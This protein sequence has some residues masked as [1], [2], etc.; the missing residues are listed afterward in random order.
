MSLSDRQKLKAL[1]MGVTISALT[2]ASTATADSNAMKTPDAKEIR[3]ETVAA[4]ARGNNDAATLQLS[5]EDFLAARVAQK[6]E[7]IRENGVEPEKSAADMRH[8]NADDKQDDNREKQQADDDRERF[9]REQADKDFRRERMEKMFSEKTTDSVAKELLKAQTENTDNQPDLDQLFDQLFETETK[10][11]AKRVARELQNDPQFK[12]SDLSFSSREGQR[13]WN[14]FVVDC[15]NSRYLK[16]L[17]KADKD[18]AAAKFVNDFEKLHKNIYSDQCYEEAQIELYKYEK[19]NDEIVEKEEKVA[20]EKINN[21]DPR[22]KTIDLN[23]YYYDSDTKIVDELSKLD[24]PAVPKQYSYDEDQKNSATREFISRLRGTSKEKPETAVKK[25][26]H[27]N[28]DQ[29][30]LKKMRERKVYN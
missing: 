24:P 14:E 8:E 17:K 16:S 7:L 29:M 10:R 20:K 4:A 25:Q 12:N 2:A 26:P 30:L 19:I 11:N 21:F 27:Q 22:G 1:R 9:D 5:A 23:Q 15:Y 28:Q 6:D 3:Q 13:Q 18:P